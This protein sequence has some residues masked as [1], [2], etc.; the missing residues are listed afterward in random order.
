MGNNCISPM[1]SIT[2]ST[3][4]TGVTSTTQDNLSTISSTDFGQ[5]TDSTATSPQGRIL[6]AP[7]L[8]IFSFAELR[9]ATKNFKPETVLGEGGFGRV[10]KG[11]VDEK[12]L[13]PTKSGLG[14]VIAVKKLKP[15]SVQGL[16][17]WQVRKFLMIG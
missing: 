6:E 16:E 17:Q 2:P 1:K 4:T 5:S 14:M 13:C 8:K 11:W 9:S 15:E 7:N 3:S 10:Y 12:T